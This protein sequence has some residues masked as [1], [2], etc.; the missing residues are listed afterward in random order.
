MGLPTE[1][2]LKIFAHFFDNR[3]PVTLFN[4]SDV[5]VLVN[6]TD[7]ENS[8]AKKA[9]KATDLL[10]VCRQIHDEAE[11]AFFN[12]T[13]FG[14]IA[15]PYQ[16]PS[17][18]SHG[19]EGI[20]SMPNAFIPMS[21]LQRVRRVLLVMSLRGSAYARY[22]YRVGDLR[23]LQA[24]TNLRDVRLVFAAPI[25]LSLNDAHMAPI[26]A[27]VESVPS[28][29]RIQFGPQCQPSSK[30]KGTKEHEKNNGQS[31]QTANLGESDSRR[32]MYVFIRRYK[33]TIND[34]KGILSG[35][36]SDHGGCAFQKCAEGKDCANSTM[37]TLPPKKI[38]V[39]SRF[40]HALAPT[41]GAN[42]SRLLGT[43]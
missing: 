26:R 43:A 18:V 12:R 15:S 7:G 37:E 5:I 19:V 39:I 36:T 21:T 35:S 40:L 17:R 11:D 29:A 28:M 32:E 42:S 22:G 1:L 9:A 31:G 10:R 14:I 4:G 20:R 41:G 30:D 3:T 2:R 16:Q 6:S 8:N 24:M 34:R 33:E 38:K 27:I 25:N 13:L 23:W